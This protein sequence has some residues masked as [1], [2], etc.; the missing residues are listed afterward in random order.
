MDENATVQ[1]ESVA[2]TDATTDS[3]ESLSDVVDPWEALEKELNVIDPDDELANN[4]DNADQQKPDKQTET[5]AEDKSQDEETPKSDPTFTL[6]HL[7]EEKTVTADE[8]KALAQK[9]M[10]YDRIKNRNDEADKMATWLADIA[11]D[12]GMSVSD[13]K[14]RIDNMRDEAKIAAL[15]EANKDKGWTPEFAREKYLL[16]KAQ[17]EFNA[18]LDAE[19]KKQTDADAE[20]RKAAEKRETE[21][22]EFSAEHPDVAVDKI[23]A[24]VWDA[25]KAGK[26]LL[27]AYDAWDIKQEKARLEAEKKNLENKTKSTGSKQSA[28]NKTAVDPYVASWYDD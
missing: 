2:D 24:E 16:D 5:K 26:S 18:K 28:G 21:I 20:T 4:Q 19:S 1:T 23:P 8:M 14:E 10:D 7:G 15:F 25:V 9:G 13:F 27:N 11:K 22:K 12:D 3:I 17:K 6:K